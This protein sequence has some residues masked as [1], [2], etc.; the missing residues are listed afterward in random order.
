M[1]LYVWYPALEDYSAGVIFVLAHSVKE[2]RELM[3]K[4]YGP[5]TSVAREMQSKPRVFSR[6]AVGFAVYG[7]G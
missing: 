7:G 5:N 4:E 3:L 2:A 6:K 1:K